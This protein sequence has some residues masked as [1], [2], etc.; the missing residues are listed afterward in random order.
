M[1]HPLHEIY[2][3]AHSLRSIKHNQ[4]HELYVAMLIKMLGLSIVGVFVPVYLYQLGYGIDQIALFYVVLYGTRAITDNIAVRI[5]GYFGPKHVMI[6]SHLFLLLSLTM[7]LSLETIIWPLAAIAVVDALASGMFY[8][9]YHIEF[10]KISSDKHSGHQIGTMYK[11][12]KFASAAGPVLGGAVATIFGVQVTIV[13]A[14]VLILASGVPL[15]LS[16]E[17][18]RKRQHV[19]LKGFPWKKVQWD[20]VSNAG[21]GFDQMAAMFI[22][23]LYVSVFI[24]TENVYLSV[25]LI[26]SLGLAVSFAVAGLYGRVIDKGHGKA[27]LNLGVVGA[28][29]S[30]LL[31]TIISSSGFVYLF[32]FVNDS[33]G[34]AVRMPYTKG[35]Y[36]AASSYEG[37]RDAYIGLIMTSS[38]IMRAGVFVIVFWVSQTNSDRL[39]LQSVFI[40]AALFL[41]LTPLQRYRSLQ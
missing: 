10:S 3:A 38:N 15:A 20:L 25:G 29:A 22:W 4:L 34:I 2:H 6:L 13:L 7:L 17:P 18:V 8:T 31:R 37:F 33:I 21:L 28:S 23:P 16:P 30:H 19:T 14:M 5:V 35:L 11:V 32:N 1:V 41:W 40:L 26:T 36:G 27:L 39:A 24:F 9:A 12:G